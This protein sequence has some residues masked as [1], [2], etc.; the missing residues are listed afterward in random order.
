MAS[1]A[2]EP[3]LA[4]RVHRRTEIT[5]TGR[6]GAGREAVRVHA[7]PEFLQPLR[8]DNLSHDRSPERRDAPGQRP[9]G[10]PRGLVGG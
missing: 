4:V 10:P 6:A 9:G 1:P 2:P 8:G 5:P 3:D 7:R